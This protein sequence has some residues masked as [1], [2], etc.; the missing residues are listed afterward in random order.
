MPINTFLILMQN[1]V[2]LYNYMYHNYFYYKLHR[3]VYILIWI[4]DI[5][6]VFQKSF[7]EL[8]FY[9]K[10]DTCTLYT[11]MYE[12]KSLVKIVLL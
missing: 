3:F 12:Q 4:I 2:M 5:Q 11:S 8:I 6:I 10:T 7:F 1:V 9:Q